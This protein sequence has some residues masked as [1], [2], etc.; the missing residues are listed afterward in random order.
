MPPQ[1]ARRRERPDHLG[2]DPVGEQAQALLGDPVAPQPRAHVRAD[3]RDEIEPACQPAI[4]PAQQ[5]THAR[6]ADQAERA[7]RL[8]LQILD[9]Q[10]RL[11]AAQPGCEESDRRGAGRGLDRPHQLG[12]KTRRLPQAGHQ[13]ARSERQQVQDPGKRRGRGRHPQ[14]TAQQMNRAEGLAPPH[15]GPV[16][17]RN[18]PFRVV[19]RG[20]DHPH[21][22]APLA[23][24][25]GEISGASPCAGRFRGKVQAQDEIFTG[26]NSK[27]NYARE[28]LPQIIEGRQ[29]FFTL[30]VKSQTWRSRYFSL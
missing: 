6:P 26:L 29:A 7:K 20:G 18:P 9:V 5:A 15:P 30:H 12:P 28:H 11:G 2:V 24:P 17:A 14:R 3:G 27:E 16:A 19:G 10:A 8:R 21:V 1:Q 4:G 13:A 23:Q 25:E 22:M